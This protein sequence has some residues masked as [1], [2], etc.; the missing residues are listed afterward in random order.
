MSKN[1]IRAAVM[2][3]AAAPMIA[4]G[5]G[6]AVAEPATPMPVEVQ[7]AVLSPFIT[8]PGAL[9]TCVPVLVTLPILYPLCV[10]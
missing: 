8:I 7:P 1:R 5:T 4:L 9:L 10:V 3:A 6:V 2:V